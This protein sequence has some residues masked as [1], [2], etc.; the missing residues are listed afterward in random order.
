EQARKPI[1][2]RQ[3][4]RAEAGNRRHND[5]PVTCP[6]DNPAGWRLKRHIQT[7]VNMFRPKM[8]PAIIPVKVG[9]A[10]ITACRPDS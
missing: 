5:V 2:A 7:G 9:A 4:Q 1:A 6:A 3:C 8:S 10:L